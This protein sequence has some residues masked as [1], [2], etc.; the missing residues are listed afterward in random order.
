[1]LTPQSVAKQVSKSPLDR[2]SRGQIFMWRGLAVADHS[3]A[4][5]DAWSTRASLSSGNGYERDPLMRPFAN[6]AAIYPMLQIAPFGADYLSHRFMRS[7]HAF[8]RRAW[9]VPQVASIGSSM[10]CGARNLH[11]ADL[12]R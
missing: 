1:M 9:W 11:V 5:F 2:P 4:L 8:L 10:W 6:S 3:A 12:K 7:N